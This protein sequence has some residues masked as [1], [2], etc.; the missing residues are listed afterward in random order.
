MSVVVAKLVT[1]L[2]HELADAARTLE[3]Q[4]LSA[5]RSVFFRFVDDVLTTEEVAALAES[6]KLVTSRPEGAPVAAVERPKLALVDEDEAKKQHA[7][8]RRLN[9]SMFPSNIS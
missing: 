7:E 8:H 4:A 5:V 3:P 2:G 6:R 9:P 1:W